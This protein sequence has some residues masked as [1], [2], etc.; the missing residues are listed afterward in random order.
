VFHA[1]CIPISQ[2][3]HITLLS[4]YYVGLFWSSVYFLQLSPSI[5]LVNL[6]LQ[7]AEVPGP[8]GYYIYYCFKP[9]TC[10]QVTPLLVQRIVYDGLPQAARI[11]QF[12]RLKPE[13]ILKIC[14]RSCYPFPSISEQTDRQ[15]ESRTGLYRAQPGLSRRPG[16][17]RP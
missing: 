12:W 7:L 15:T 5:T 17:L 16:R 2:P 8:D 6:I 14:T 9:L 11:D 3:A 10:L 4:V 13:T 1:V